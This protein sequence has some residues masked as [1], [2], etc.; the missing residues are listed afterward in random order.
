[1]IEEGIFKVKATVSDN[2][3]DGEDFDSHL[4][5]YFIQEFKHKNKKDLLLNPCVLHHLCTAC[6]CAKHTLS[7]TTQT[8]IEIDLLY[9]GIDFYTSVTCTCFKELSQDHFYSMLKPVEADL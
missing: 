9:E 4:V 3:L 1:M 8:S 7:S 2:H 6:K 5:D